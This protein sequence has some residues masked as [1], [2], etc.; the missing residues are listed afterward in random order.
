[1]D[2]LE[3]EIEPISDM[4]VSNR[5]QADAS[6]R[7]GCGCGK[8]LTLV[9]AFL[10]LFAAA[11]WYAIADA[12]RIPDFYAQVLDADH[13]QAKLDGQQFER[14]LIRLQNSAR[15]RKP[16]KVEISQDQFNGWLAHDLVEKFPNSIPSEIL[17]PRAVFELNE[18]KLAFRYRKNGLEG[19]IVVTADIFCTDQQNE[20]AVEIKGVRA[21]FIP[22][23]VGPWIDKVT[24]TLAEAGIPL[25]WTTTSDSPIAVFSIPEHLSA[26]GNNRQ[27]VIEAI[28]LSSKKLLIAGTTIENEFTAN[29]ENVGNGTNEQKSPSPENQDNHTP[30]AQRNGGTAK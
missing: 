1:M 4:S 9:V 6:P 25:F 14:N 7:S 13:P 29:A 19:I 8:V 16:W 5:D 21:G 10:M 22:L 12:Q 30:K 26:K 27:A 18:F 2:Q 24:D 28:E 23:P 15:Q 20:I 17:E 11:I 3:A